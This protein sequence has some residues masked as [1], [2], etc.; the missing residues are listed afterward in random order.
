MPPIWGDFGGTPSVCYQGCSGLPFRAWL[1]WVV[2]LACFMAVKE[3]VSR[4]N[5]ENLEVIFGEVPCE[6]GFSLHVVLVEGNASLN[7]IR[8]YQI[9][10]PN[11]RVRLLG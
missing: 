5:L 1:T 7:V 8:G 4:E 3:V 2:S 11:I 9:L 10:L 6:G